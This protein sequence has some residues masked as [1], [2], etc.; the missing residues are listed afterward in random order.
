MTRYRIWLTAAFLLSLLM[1][2]PK[3]AQSRQYFDATI[4]FN[5]MA[6][7]LWHYQAG[8]SLTGLEIEPGKRTNVGGAIWTIYDE[9]INSSG[10]GLVG[11]HVRFNTY[12]SVNASG[13]VGN[14]NPSGGPTRPPDIGTPPP[15]DLNAPL[16]PPDQFQS[17]G[18]AGSIGGGSSG[19]DGETDLAGEGAFE[20]TPIME[21]N[22]NYVMSES[23]RMLDVSGLDMIGDIID[24]SRS[25]TVRQV[26]QTVHFVTLPDYQVHLGESWRAPMSWTIPYVGETMDIPLTYTLADIRTTYRFRMAAIDLKGILQFEVDTSDEGTLEDPDTGDLQSVRKESHISG[27][28]IVYGRAYVDL[29]RGILVAICDTPEFGYTGFVDGD[30]RGWDPFSLSPGFY[31]NLAFERRDL[32]TPLGNVIDQRQE[33][34]DRIQELEWYTIVVVE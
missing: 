7:N 2:S 11:V 1:F 33:V 32:Y 21:S 10:N 27:D 34:I 4:R 14:E 15:E 8:I 22:L 29:D 26:F 18:G 30:N 16:Q 6:G 13:P 24:P 20:V 3:D 25:V 12:E 5:P 17:G 28:I 31:A 19:G 9:E 23:G